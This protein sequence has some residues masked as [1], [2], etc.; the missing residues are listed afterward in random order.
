MRPAIMLRRHFQIQGADLAVRVFVFDAQI[1]DMHLLVEVRQVVRAGPFLD[2]LRRAIRLAGTVPIARIPCLEKALVLAFQ[3]AVEGDADD[4]RILRV[5]S[6]RGLQIGAIDLDV[7][8]AFPRLVGA[9]IERLLRLMIAVATMVSS[10]PRPRSVRATA[11]S[12]PSTGTR[13]INPSCR[14]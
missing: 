2:F 7:V 9:C 8:C 10:R 3:L 1:G 14:R 11:W 13:R 6:L 12:R 4:A 5:Q